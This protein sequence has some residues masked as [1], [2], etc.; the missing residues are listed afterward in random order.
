VSTVEALAGAVDAHYAGT[1]AVVGMFT[2]GLAIYESYTGTDF[3]TGESLNG[4][5]RFDRAM[6]GTS[7]IMT[8]VGFS[9]PAPPILSSSHRSRNQYVFEKVPAI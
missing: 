7:G 9:I 5:H 2:G 6:L 4:D 8:S 1:L 3:L